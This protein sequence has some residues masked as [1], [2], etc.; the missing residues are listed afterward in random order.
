MLSLFLIWLAIVQGVP[1]LDVPDAPVIQS[2]DVPWRV[3]LCCQIPT[4][5]QRKESN[6]GHSASTPPGWRDINGSP[7]QCR[8]NNF[9]DGMKREYTIQNSTGVCLNIQCWLG[10][11]KEKLIC[12]H[13]LDSLS[14]DILVAFTL[15]QWPAGEDPGTLLDPPVKEDHEGYC[16]QD[17]RPCF[18][19]LNGTILPSVFLIV[20]V[21]NSI[22]TAVSPAL[23][24]DTKW[25]NPPTNLSY[26]MKPSEKPVLKWIPPA[27]STEPLIYQ[28]RYSSAKHSHWQLLPAVDECSQALKNISIYSHDLYTVQVRSQRLGTQEHWSNWS[29]PLYLCLS[30]TCYKSD[31]VFTS[32]GSEVTL[33]C[34]TK[35]SW[36]NGTGAYWLLNHSVRLPDSQSRAVNDHVAI[37]TWRPTAVGLDTL[38]CCRKEQGNHTC[39][40]SY[41]KVYTQGNYSADIKC[42]T[43]ATN[44]AMICTWKQKL[45]KEKERL[46]IV[47]YKGSCEDG[48]KKGDSAWSSVGQ[49]D[50]QRC[51]LKD[52]FFHSCYKLWS[53]VVKTEGR[54]SSLPDYIRPIDWVKPDPPIDVDV[55]TMP[56]KSMY[57][58]WSS[59]VRSSAREFKFRY[60][61][62]SDSTKPMIVE[63]QQKT[64][65]YVTV[66]DPCAIYKVEVS[67]RRQQGSGYWSDWSLPRHS[68]ISNCRAPDRGPEFWRKPQE[69]SGNISLLFKFPPNEDPTC[70]VEKVVIQH[71]TSGG[72]N[73]SRVIN[74]G[75]LYSL[76]LEQEPMI[77]T[78][79]ALNSR[80]ISS[81]N[82]IMTLA[83]MKRKA[84]QSC[85]GRALNSTCVE[86]SWSMMFHKPPPQGFVIQ[87]L[88]PH[89]Q[90]E[91]QW[92]RVAPSE[93]AVVCLENGYFYGVDQYNFTLHA[94]Y[95]DGEGEPVQCT[96]SKDPAIEVLLIVILI[97]VLVIT[98][99]LSQN[100]LK[101]FVWHNVPDP[102]QSTWAQALHLKNGEKI[103]SLF[104]HPDGLTAFPLLLQSDIISAA[105]IVEKSPPGHLNKDPGREWDSEASILI[106]DSSSVSTAPATGLDSRGTAEDVLR[107]AESS[108]QSTASEHSLVTYSNVQFNK[109]IDPCRLFEGSLET[110]CSSSDEGN[111]SSNNSDISGSFA[112]DIWA[113][114]HLASRSKE[115]TPRHSWSDESGSL[116]ETTDGTPRERLSPD[117]Y[118]LE[119][120]CHSDQGGDTDDEERKKT[121]KQQDL[122]LRSF[123]E[124]KVRLYCQQATLPSSTSSPNFVSQIGK[125]LYLPQFP[126]TST[127][128][129][130]CLVEHSSISL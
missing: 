76:P 77:I 105:L 99:V 81:K 13:E 27:P 61:P 103:E 107:T 73:W 62:L 25:L 116:E 110:V 60:S 127:K 58:S 6:R 119:L 39:D 2:E 117:L 19:T 114:E 31:V 124:E 111:F 90:M 36:A 128:S 94:L 126:S 15:G 17:S 42:V 112:E 56:N 106:P 92:Q 67:F 98:L 108:G 47:Y 66:P 41:V 78:A 89:Q 49:C 38:A 96:S 63:N 52:I 34:F 45:L 87:W 115:P 70:C 95:N 16:S 44:N 121:T 9:I 113:S 74:V 100:Q 18:L 123:D 130:L 7:L 29:Q 50:H 46:M 79:M 88:N 20:T 68:K 102:K 5:A 57:I 71:Q 40:I 8:K 48:L 37:L 122:E 24:I 91:V 21:T 14:T 3:D 22:G 97:L 84:V 33:Q 64:F 118:Y 101:R 86:L 69:D 28:V 54:M 1:L 35:F 80:G 83:K 11:G 109:K 65:A 82:S 23:H 55:F 32:L 10:E 4:A 120:G 125:P 93:K 104:R 43:N 30:E 53:E 59:S 51:V 26:T 75:D 12:V 85:S 72:A 129:K